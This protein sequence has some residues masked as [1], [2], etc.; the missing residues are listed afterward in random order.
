M[1]VASI[2][3]NPARASEHAARVFKFRKW[4]TRKGHETGAVAPIAE[5][6]LNFVFTRVVNH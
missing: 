5:H 4:D 2:P 1:K 3:W 6:F